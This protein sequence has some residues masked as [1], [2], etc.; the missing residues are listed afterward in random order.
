MSLLTDVLKNRAFL[1]GESVRHVSKARLWRWY[2]FHPTEGLSPL[3][4]NEGEHRFSRINNAVAVILFGNPRISRYGRLEHSIAIGKMVDGEW[5]DYKGQ[6]RHCSWRRYSEYMNAVKGEGNHDLSDY[7]K[8]NPIPADLLEK[9][10]L[11]QDG[12][13]DFPELKK[14]RRVKNGENTE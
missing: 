14:K 2:D 9:L 13:W 3:L 10:E 1:I 6:P 8:E 5:V 4:G 12:Q 7:F 11:D